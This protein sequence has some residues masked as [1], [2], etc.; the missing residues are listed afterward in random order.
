[1]P[2]SRISYVLSVLT[3]IPL[4]F[5]SQHIH[6]RH[7][8]RQSLTVPTTLPNT[9]TSQGCVTDSVGARTLGGASYTDGAGMTIESCIAFCDSKSFTFSG[10]EYSDQC[11]CGNSILNGAVNA[12]ES[13]C[14]MPCAGDSAEPCGA[15]NRLNVFWNG[16]SSSAPIIVPSVGNWVSLGCYSDNVDGRALPI[17]GAVTGQVT[18]ESCTTA[19]FNAGYQF[20]GAEYADE[21][22][23][24]TA[25][26]NGGAPAEAGD[27]N[28]LCAGNSTEYCGGP[29]R[30]NMYNYTGTD[31]PT[32]R[33][34]VV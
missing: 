15:A 10:V 32:D 26:V 4:S 14:N 31:L 17:A 34:S 6:S 28:M 9:W 33:K 13:D 22:Y 30:L 2:L 7:H 3:V 21:C 27:C 11:Y 23:C 29:N 20:S 18:I 19:C 1:M 5:A 24:N 8:R 25:I 16:K 12:T